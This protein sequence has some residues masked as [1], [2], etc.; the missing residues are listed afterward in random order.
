[1]IRP[2]TCHQV[3]TSH[4]GELRRAHM[5]A[6]RSEAWYRLETNPLPLYNVRVFLSSRTE[7]VGELWSTSKAATVVAMF[8]ASFWFFDDSV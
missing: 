8:L 5:E 4:P 7:C 1:M 3:R 6:L 2:G